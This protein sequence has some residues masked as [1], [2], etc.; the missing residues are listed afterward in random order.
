MGKEKIRIAI[1]GFGK[2]GRCIARQILQQDPAIEIAAIN[3]LG[4]VEALAHLLKYDSVHGKL[5]NVE[6]QQGEI[7]VNG[8]RIQVYA[9]K[10]PGKLPWN[11][12]EID[13]VVESTGLFNKRENAKNHLAVGAKKVLITAPAKNPDATI[14][15]GVNDEIYKP[16]HRIISLASCTTNCLA[17]IAK[18]LN[19]EF[20]IESGFMTTVHAYTGDQM[21]CDGAHKDLRRARAAAMSIIPT[22]TG[23]AKSIGEV[24]SGL[25]GKFDGLCLR[26]PTPN[27]SLVDLVVQ[28]KKKAVRQEINNKF[29]LAAVEMGKILSVSY[30]PLVSVDYIGNSHSSIVDA[31]TTSVIK[32][33]GKG[34]LVKVLAWY[35]NE[36]GYSCRV[37]DMLKKIH[38]EG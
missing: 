2:I 26:V 15:L 21:L 14:V 1:N 12:L 32:N 16:E 5:F 35:D 17:P 31:L 37:V 30:E 11:D 34:S 23:A 36:W 28:L 38:R 18:V 29:E 27:V 20:G 3:D 33:S 13:V 6:Y 4:E 19:D 22:T 24:I 7:I 25:K 8:N 9:E 10:D